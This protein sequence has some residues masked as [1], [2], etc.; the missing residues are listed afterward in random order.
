MGVWPFLLKKYHNIDI[1]KIL[2]KC[3][4]LFLKVKKQLTV[5]TDENDKETIHCEFDI[6]G[7]ELTWASGKLTHCVLGN[8]SCFFVIC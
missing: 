4:H 3:V 8:F 6:S 1:I 5:C 2:R 7:S